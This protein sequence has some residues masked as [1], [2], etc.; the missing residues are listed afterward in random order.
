VVPEVPLP[1][2]KIPDRAGFDIITERNIFDVANQ[3]ATAVGG[4]EEGGNGAATATSEGPAVKTS[5]V[6]QVL[7]TL[8]VG[9]G[10]DRRSSAVIESSKAKE[11]LRTYRV[12]E[13]LDFAGGGA[14]VKVAKDRIEFMNGH[15]LEY[16]EIIGLELKSTV[17]IG[18]DKPGD[19]KKETKAAAPEG[20][21]GVAKIAEGKYVIDQREIDAALANLDQLYT[22]I[23]A[24]PNFKDGKV[25]GLK[26]LSVRAESLFAKLGLKRGDILERINGID[27]DIKKGLEIFNQ[28]KDQKSLTIDIVRKGAPVTMDYEIR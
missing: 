14:L 7:G 5:L 25:A 20:G 10:I 8:A 21:E 2:A 16:A 4:E 9:E 26:L 6:V 24:V 18:P 17:S 12:G 15:R 23:R 22:E 27:L 11:R 28:L 3:P 19:V 1:E 13:T